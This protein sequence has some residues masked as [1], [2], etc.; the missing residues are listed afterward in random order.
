M[1]RADSLQFR[2]PQSLTTDLGA[3]LTSRH[4]LPRNMLFSF[5]GM[6]NRTER[7][8][9]GS[10]L[11]LNWMRETNFGDQ[12]LDAALL[13]KTPWGRNLQAQG[14]DLSSGQAELEYYPVE[15]L[16]P[17]VRNHL[18]HSYI[19]QSKLEGGIGGT[20]FW[21]AQGGFSALSND[22]HMTGGNANQDVL[23]QMLY[24]GDFVPGENS[25]L[26]RGN[27]YTNVQCQQ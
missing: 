27:C 20:W 10:P 1:C 24:D 25:D 17:Q 14:L 12:S 16:G 11:K 18:E 4:E 26:S 3:L 23:R 2:N 8:S 5:L 15:E 22:S 7:E 21:T 6:Y 9:V 13:A 19:V